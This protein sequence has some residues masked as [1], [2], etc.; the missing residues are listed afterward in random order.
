L[1]EQAD[2]IKV[3]ESQTDLSKVIMLET[4]HNQPITDK[5]RIP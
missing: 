1:Q 3:K 2:Y 5:V 4:Q